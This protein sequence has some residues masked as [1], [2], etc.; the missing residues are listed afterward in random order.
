M[1]PFKIQETVKVTVLDYLQCATLVVVNQV[2]L[3]GCLYIAWEIYD[4]S[5][6]GGFDKDLPSPMT[7]LTHGLCYLPM[8]EFCFYFPHALMHKN[9]WLWEHV[10][11]V[12][13]SWTAPIAMSARK[14]KKER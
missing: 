11:K 9:A 3:L 13:H 8:A 12:H 7:I 1:L 6:D 2:V 10:H 5:N 14:K 4:V